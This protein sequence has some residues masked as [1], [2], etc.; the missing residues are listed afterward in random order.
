MKYIAYAAAMVLLAAIISGCRFKN[1]S[2]ISIKNGGILIDVRS[3]EEFKEGYLPGAVNIPHTAVASKISSVAPDKSTPLYLYCR[4]GRRVGIA[5]E[6]LK[7]L[8]YTDMTNLGGLNDAA[9]IL[10]T[11]PVKP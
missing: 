1:N 5:M 9:K 6:A 8:G 2:E 10:N 7:E 4:S 11:K 3:E